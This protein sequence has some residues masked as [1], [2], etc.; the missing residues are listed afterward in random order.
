MILLTPP[1]RSVASLL[2]DWAVFPW[3]T[4]PRILIV[5]DE[6]G[7]AGLLGQALARRGHDVRSCDNSV[8]AV[9]LAA[10]LIPEVLVLDWMLGQGTERDNVLAAVVRVSP[11]VRVI[12][13]TGLRADQI[14][15]GTPVGT[16][17]VLE[18]PFSVDALFD[19]VDRVMGP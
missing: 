2:T 8:E 12:V 13:A 1:I 14:T 6:P 7:F 15:L 18:K 3:S 19:A 10:T 4:M 5:D 11:Q 17:M 16:W 9:L